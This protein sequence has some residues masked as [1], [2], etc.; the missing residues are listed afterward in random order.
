MDFAKRYD[1]KTNKTD[2]LGF[3]F[4]NLSLGWDF[5]FKDGCY[6]SVIVVNAGATTEQEQLHWIPEAKKPA[7]T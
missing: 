4:Q 5:F 6:S 2:C 7:V 3:T 1:P